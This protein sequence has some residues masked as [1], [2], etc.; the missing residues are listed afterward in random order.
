VYGKEL[1]GKTILLT[2]EAYIQYVQMINMWISQ[3]V[4]YYLENNRENLRVKPDGLYIKEGEEE[5][6]LIR[7]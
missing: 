5:I 6:C 4:Q 2:E 1:S 3:Q 7:K